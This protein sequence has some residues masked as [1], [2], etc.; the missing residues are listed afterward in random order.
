LDSLHL[1]TA[2]MIRVSQ[3]RDQ[4]PLVFAT[5]DREL[6]AAARAVNFE[7]IGA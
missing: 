3:P 4:S 6:A 2:L 7:V 1:T 5:H